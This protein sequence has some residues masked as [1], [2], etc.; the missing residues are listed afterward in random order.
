MQNDKNCLCPTNYGSKW[1]WRKSS[2]N[3]QTSSNLIWRKE[4]QASVIKLFLLCCASILSLQLTVHK[5]RCNASPVHFHSW[6]ADSTCS[7]DLH[8]P[9]QHHPAART[10]T[11]GRRRRRSSTQTQSAS[12]QR[13]VIIVHVWWRRSHENSGVC[14]CLRPNSWLPF[15]LSWPPIG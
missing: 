14:I 9:V 10:P 8:L 6:A 5:G 12:R 11:A 15:S 4:K 13:S 1:K 2:P 7:A 3:L